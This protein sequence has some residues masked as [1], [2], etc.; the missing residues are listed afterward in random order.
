MNEEQWEPGISLLEWEV[1][2]KPREKARTIDVV[3]DQW[4]TLAQ[5]HI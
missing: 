1:T 4:E 5:I 3:I 2:D